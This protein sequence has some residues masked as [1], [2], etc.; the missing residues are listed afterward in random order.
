MRKNKTYILM[1]VI[2]IGIILVLFAQD[3]QKTKAIGNI[4]IEKEELRAKGIVKDSYW[5][6]K[7]NDGVFNIKIKNIISI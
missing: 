7:V 6:D 4:E 1:T 2:C 3:L 5:N